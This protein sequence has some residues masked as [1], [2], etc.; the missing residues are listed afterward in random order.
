MHQ[1]KPHPIALAI[2][3]ALFTPLTMAQ[4]SNTSENDEKA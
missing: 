1:I 3:L 4:Q 2:T